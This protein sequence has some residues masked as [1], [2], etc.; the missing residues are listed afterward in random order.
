MVLKYINDDKEEI[1]SQIVD[2]NVKKGFSEKVSGKV[3]THNSV[4]TVE[5]IGRMDNLKNYDTREISLLVKDESGNLY[6][7]QTT[8][9]D[10]GG[11]SFKFQYSG[12]DVEKADIILN[13]GGAVVNDTV[14]ERISELIKCNVTASEDAGIITVVA[15]LENYYDLNE[16]CMVVVAGYDAE[17]K[18]SECYLS[19]IRQIKSGLSNEVYNMK[20]PN[21][22]NT[23]IFVWNDAVRMRPLASVN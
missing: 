6:V 1:A 22:E 19:D 7:D 20:S 13:V 2:I 10:N 21:V 15:E 4:Q 18:L 16:T 11:Y 3:Y 12:D 17:G 5:I 23:K 9:D 14:V 8:I